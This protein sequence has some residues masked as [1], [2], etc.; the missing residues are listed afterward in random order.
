MLAPVL[1]APE[2]VGARQSVR[3]KC[4]AESY[5]RPAHAREL[6][7]ALYL[8]SRVSTGVFWVP[9]PPGRLAIREGKAP[10]Q[11][12]SRWAR[13]RPAPRIPRP[14]LQPWA[15]DAGSAGRCLYL[16]VF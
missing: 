7:C 11:Q 4:R 16:L 3:P 10:A 9:S 13:L 2:L 8:E 1:E 12:R 5:R 14:W 6:G 15:P